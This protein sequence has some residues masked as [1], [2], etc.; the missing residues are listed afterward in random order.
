[1]LI[2]IKIIMLLIFDRR[3]IEP[4]HE[5][6]VIMAIS[7]VHVHVQKCMYI[8]LVR[9][10]DLNFTLNLPLLSYVLYASSEG[11]DETALKRSLV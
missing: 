8:H 6:L 2:L 9:T 10:R 3:N 4:V 11:S 5:I 7:Y 1:M